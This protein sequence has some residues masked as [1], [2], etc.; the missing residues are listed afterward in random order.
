MWMQ[1][2]GTMHQRAVEGRGD[3]VRTVRSDC[4]RPNTLAIIPPLLPGDTAGVSHSGRSRIC[5]TQLHLTRTVPC[6]FNRHLT[7]GSLPPCKYCGS[8]ISRRTD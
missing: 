5:P 6:D 4:M 3:L 2:T 7:V 1:A 8:M